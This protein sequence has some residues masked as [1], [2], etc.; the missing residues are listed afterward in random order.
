[1]TVRYRRTVF[2]GGQGVLLDAH[3]HTRLEALDDE[4][5]DVCDGA[6][7]V[8]CGAFAFVVCAAFFDEV[9][10]GRCVLAVGRAI[11]W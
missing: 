4:S 11:E 8:P 5:P 2:L 9:A 3:I 1:M 10:S 7:G 6:C